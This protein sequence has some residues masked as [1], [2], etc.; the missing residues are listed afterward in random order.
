MA[1]AAAFRLI[2]RGPVDRQHAPLA[3]D[4]KAVESE[5]L[6]LEGRIHYCD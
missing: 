2:E 6:R 1:Q 3:P 4:R 5:N